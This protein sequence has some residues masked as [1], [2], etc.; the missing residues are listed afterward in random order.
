MEKH[1]MTPEGQARLREELQRLK[2]S[3]RPSIIQEIAQ[4]R[5]HGDIS[6]NAEYHAAKERQGMVEA[7]IQDLE[8]KLSRAEVIDVTKLS[9]SHVQFGAIVTIVD[10]DT[11]QESTYQLLG[12]DEAEVNQGRLSISSPLAR[13]LLGKSVGDAVE[14]DTPGGHRNYEITAV[15]FQ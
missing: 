13:A 4:A 3:E 2:S 5:E 14:I 10:E 1:P 11:E 12:A 7:R 6:E 15:K 8:T 9:G